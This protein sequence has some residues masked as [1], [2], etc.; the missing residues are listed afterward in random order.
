MIGIG[1]RPGSAVYDTGIGGRAGSSVYNT[2]RADYDDAKAALSN[3]SLYPVFPK[4]PIALVEASVV[5][6]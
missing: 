5:I 6:D 1:G 2:C 3:P 4:L